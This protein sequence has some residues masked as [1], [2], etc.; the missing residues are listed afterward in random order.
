[1]TDKYA[2]IERQIDSL[3]NEGFYSQECTEPD[4]IANTM[5]L[6]L[7]VVRAADSLLNID[8]QGQGGIYALRSALAK[9]ND[10]PT[11]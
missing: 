10:S 3:K 4:K 6:M 1:M 7:E 11:E 9:L 8:K 2:Q 5:R